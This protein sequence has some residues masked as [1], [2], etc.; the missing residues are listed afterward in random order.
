MSDQTP[1]VIVMVGLPRSGKSTLAGKLRDRFHLP[2]VCPDCVRLA[3]HGQ[4]YSKQAE[5]F[6]WATVYA[7]AEALLLAGHEGIIVD[8]T[9]M[10]KALRER[11]VRPEWRTGFIHVDTPVNECL[12]RA[13]QTKRPDLL[14]IINQ[15]AVRFETLE[16]HERDIILNINP[17]SEDW[18]Q[19]DIR[20]T[21]AAR[22]PDTR[23]VD[24]VLLHHLEVPFRGQP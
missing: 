3:L 24:P 4:I 17:K 20:L 10:T 23:G 8:A 11:W 22:K 21:T 6:V 19:V 12:R 5:P 14:P 18:N 2:V 13:E 1:L 7:M 16:F 15:M 9:S